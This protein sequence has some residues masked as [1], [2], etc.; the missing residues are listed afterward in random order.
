M[1]LLSSTLTGKVH[2]RNIHDDPSTAAFMK[3]FTLGATLGP[4]ELGEHLAD[5]NE[6]GELPD[7]V[8]WHLALYIASDDVSERAFADPEVSALNEQYLS[9]T[10]GRNSEDMSPKER[11]EAERLQA[12]WE[13]A[14]SAAMARLERTWREA[15]PLFELVLSDRDSPAAEALANSGRAALVHAGRGV[16]W[17]FR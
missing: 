10:S 5:W 3:G 15:H 16:S 9:L 17:L 7:D 8:T 13:A 1:S 6:G 11:E 12:A 2:A 4:R 14:D